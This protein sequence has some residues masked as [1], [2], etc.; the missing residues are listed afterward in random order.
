MHSSCFPKQYI[1]HKATVWQCCCWQCWEFCMTSSQL[2]LFK[3]SVPH[4]LYSVLIHVS[5]IGNHIKKRKKKKNMRESKQ[6]K[7]NTQFKWEFELFLGFHKFCPIR[8]LIKLCFRWTILS[9][10]SLLLG[11]FLN[12]FFLRYSLIQTRL[13]ITSTALWYI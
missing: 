8:T 2:C 3:F 11:L 1:A 9:I 6:M 10:S 13:L 12:V 4:K 5:E 7:I